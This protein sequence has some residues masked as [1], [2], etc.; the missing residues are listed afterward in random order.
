M[1]PKITWIFEIGQMYFSERYKL[2]PQKIPAVIN[3]MKTIKAIMI[4]TSEYMLK[5]VL[6][7][8]ADG[9]SC[10]QVQVLFQY[11][12]LARGSDFLLLGGTIV[13]LYFNRV[14]SKYVAMKNFCSIMLI[15]SQGSFLISK[16]HGN[17]KGSQG[18]YKKQI[19]I[20]V[21]S[22]YEIIESITRNYKR[23]IE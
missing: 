3:S 13:N 4:N 12:G 14:I 21:W 15:I 23:N 19:I 10:Q 2:Y 8:I 1:F 9:K 18:I 22:N 6:F 7:K 20:L 16:R 11:I 17:I 5:T